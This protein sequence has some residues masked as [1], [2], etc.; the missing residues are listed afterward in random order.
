MEVKT[1]PWEL[2]SLKQQVVS[3]ARKI[4][5]DINR[6][7]AAQGPR[8]FTL[9]LVYSIWKE[10]FMVLGLCIKYKLFLQSLQRELKPERTSGA[11][12]FSQFLSS[13]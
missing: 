13:S 6:N 5:P 4:T 10:M 9:Y 3:C 2:V 12:W 11:M 1:F 8:Y 7:P